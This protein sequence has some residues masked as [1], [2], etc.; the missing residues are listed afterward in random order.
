L[1]P[2]SYTELNKLY[3]LLNTN[4]S[5]KIRIE[6]HT[7]NIGNY[8]FNLNLSLKRVESVAVYLTDKGIIPERIELAG[9]SFNYPIASNLTEEGRKQNRRVTFKLIKK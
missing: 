9:Y 7:D 1:L 4:P 6:G 5:I 8:Q 2:G 3:Y